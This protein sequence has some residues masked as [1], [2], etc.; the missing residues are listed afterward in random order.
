MGEP[1]MDANGEGNG[2]F[3]DRIYRMGRMDRMKD[4]GDG[5]GNLRFEI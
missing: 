4:G 3:F 1:R 5:E 2:A